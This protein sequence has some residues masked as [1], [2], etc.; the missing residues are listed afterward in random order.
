MHRFDET[1]EATTGDSKIMFII[2]AS[3]RITRAISN[4]VLT[5]IRLKY[6]HRV[7]N[8]Q[9]QLLLSP[10]IVVIDC[11]RAMTGDNVSGRRYNR[12]GGKKA[13]KYL[14]PSWR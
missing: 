3:A 12:G 1:K 2:G 14:G 5:F 13:I 8:L 9:R 10:G 7:S 6:V 4:P 11:C